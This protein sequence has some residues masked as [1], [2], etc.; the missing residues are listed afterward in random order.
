MQ[1]FLHFIKRKKED[2]RFKILY[3]IILAI[4]IFFLIYF[5]S[6][7]P[8][9]NA[10]DFLP[11]ETS[12][13][14]EWTDKEKVNIKIFDDSIPNSHKNKILSIINNEIEDIIWF[15]TKEEDNYLIKFSQ[16]IKKEYLEGLIK[17]NPE[18][19]FKVEQY[20]ILYIT[21]EEELLNI[22][23]K[24]LISDF[25]INNQRDGINIYWKNSIPDFLKDLI[26]FVNPILDNKEGVF[27]NLNNKSI[28]LFLEKNNK[29]EN[30]DLGSIKVLNNFDLLT[31]I[32]NI[33][34]DKNILNNLL[35]S[36][37]DSLPHHSLNLNN[38]LENIILLQ[39]DN[40]YL[41]ISTSDWKLI[42]NNLIDNIEVEEFSNILPDGTAYTELRQKENQNIINN[43]YLETEY[44]GIDGFWGLKSKQYYYLSNEEGM[45]KDIIKSSTNIN[46]IIY[47]CLGEVNYKI[48][49]LI[50]IKSKE[51]SSALIREYLEDNDLETINLI[52]YN[53]Y[54]SEGWK[55]CF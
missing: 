29:E 35:I 24:Y 9:I 52:H 8:D 40:N 2:N 38:I 20:Y 14:Y 10:R 13:Y 32:K 44:W 48:N 30:I 21:K 33:A 31:I 36:L 19:F 23:P 11:K 17:N 6:L 4:F 3:L 18:Y 26:V 54:V 47:S 43:M 49:N 7:E 53:D 42:V 16:K 41:L 55:L 50:Y 27:I 51:I 39:K 1:N 12:F 25:R 5:Y 46:D 37:Y 15:K 28:N 22:L 45:I 34:K